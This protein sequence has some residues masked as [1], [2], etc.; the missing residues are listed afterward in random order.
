MVNMVCVVRASANGQISF[1][2]RTSSHST[3][4][5]A[6]VYMCISPHLPPLAPLAGFKIRRV[7]VGVMRNSCQTDS[8]VIS[9]V[10]VNVE[11][12]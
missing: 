10:Y 11:T 6:F 2:I 4:V 9:F 1:I 3:D 8:M 5:H 12:I 7:R